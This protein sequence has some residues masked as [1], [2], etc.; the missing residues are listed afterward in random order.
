MCIQIIHS[1]ATES[2]P[3]SGRRPYMIAL[4]KAAI[5]YSYIHRQ[6]GIQIQHF[7]ISILMVDWKGPALGHCIEHIPAIR[8]NR[9][10]RNTFQLFI[11][12]SNFFYRISQCPCLFIKNHP[13]KPILQF[14]ISHRHI[15]T[16]CLTEI[17]VFSVRRPGRKSLP[18][19]GFS[20]T[21][22]R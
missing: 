2:N 14:L 22:I 7:Q 8:R 5:Q 18:N 11:R 17:K 4:T 9:R 6:S 13:I 3:S 20:K 10:K 12:N 1:P 19:L 21:R 15:L 16:Q